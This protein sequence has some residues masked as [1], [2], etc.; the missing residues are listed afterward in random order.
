MDNDIKIFLNRNVRLTDDG[1]YIKHGQFKNLEMFFNVHGRW[2]HYG[3][4]YNYSVVSFWDKLKV[5]WTY[6]KSKKKSVEEEKKEMKARD[7]KAK[8]VA[9]KKQKKS[10]KKV[11]K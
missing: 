3:L 11:K 10:R 1:I 6:L 7:R 4:D 8:R 2:I 9:K 5:I